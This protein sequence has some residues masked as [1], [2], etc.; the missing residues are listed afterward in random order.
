[1]IGKKLP[2]YFFLIFFSF[3]F[4]PSSLYLSL[5]FPSSA[6]EEG[7][8]SSILS[9]ARA[10]LGDDYQISDGRTL[11]EKRADD[12]IGENDM[13]IYGRILR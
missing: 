3:L 13:H 9:R 5:S 2:L 8:H 10:H 6:P 7:R 1:M 11:E 12:E 4:F